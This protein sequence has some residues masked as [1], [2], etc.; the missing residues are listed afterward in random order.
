MCCHLK[1]VAKTLS[2][3]DLI[4]SV[5]GLDLHRGPDIRPVTRNRTPAWQEQ[6]NRVTCSGLVSV[7]MRE[8]Y[9]PTRPPFTSPELKIFDK[10]MSP[11]FQDGLKI[12][13]L[14]VL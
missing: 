8:S 7:F 3:L 10:Y 5:R 12:P 14:A 4:L 1:L 9:S 11:S 13:P 6:S 2:G